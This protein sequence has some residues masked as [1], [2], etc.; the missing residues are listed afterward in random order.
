MVKKGM[1][2]ESQYICS[3]ILNEM[4]SGIPKSTKLSKV[5]SS[6]EFRMV[7]KPVS[8]I[9]QRELDAKEGKEID[10]VPREVKMLE[11]CF[12]E[13][14]DGFSIVP[15]KPKPSVV[16]SMDSGDVGVAGRAKGE[17]R[18]INS[19]QSLAISGSK[20]KPMLSDSGNNLSIPAKEKPKFSISP[21]SNA[22]S[23]S[24]SEKALPALPILSSISD[25]ITIPRKVCSQSS[26]NCK[27]EPITIS[28][29]RPKASPARGSQPSM[30]FEEEDLAARLMICP[31]I[32]I[33][34]CFDLQLKKS[35]KIQSIYKEFLLTSKPAPELLFEERRPQKFL[36]A[37]SFA[38]EDMSIK[39]KP[40]VVKV[41]R[42]TLFSL[43]S[44]PAVDFYYSKK[45]F[46][47][48]SQQTEKTIQEVTQSD[49]KP[50]IEAKDLIA[51]KPAQPGL[52]SKDTSL[53]TAAKLLSVGFGDSGLRKSELDAIKLQVKEREALRLKRKS[54]AWYRGTCVRR[55]VLPPILEVYN[56][57]LR[58]RKISKVMRKIKRTWAPYII[59]SALRRWMDLKAK[60]KEEIFNKFLEYSAVCIQRSF[61]GFRVRKVYLEQ[62]RAR[63]TVRKRLR[64]L[65]RLWKLKKILM[66]RKVQVTL[67]G[68]RD[69]VKLVN[70]IK[71]DSAAKLLYNQVLSQVPVLRARLRSD[72]IVLYKNGKWVGLPV[73]KYDPAASVIEP[74]L[75]ESMQKSFMNRD[76]M[77][78]R[79]LNS[80]YE[81]LAESRTE[82]PEGKRR[83]VSFLK[84]GGGKMSWKSGLEDKAA[85][86]IE[87]SFLASPG[88]EDEEE[89]KYS[90][91]PRDFLKRSSKKVIS[92]KL[93]WKA[94]RRID[95]WLSREPAQVSKE[96]EFDLKPGRAYMNIMHLQE[97]EEIFLEMSQSHRTIQV[98]LD[99]E[100]RSSSR[101]PAL[102]SESRFI[103]NFS[104]DKY[105]ENIEVL[106]NYYNSLCSDEIVNSKLFN[107]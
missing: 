13:E 4:L 9:F 98:Y 1:I 12:K 25:S 48:I 78:I 36:G 21:A 57:R 74:E 5:L 28:T 85:E 18:S 37:L 100:D 61:R 53:Q 102:S 103:L 65:L 92:Q 66:T 52:P 64:R 71:A 55:K 88:D 22:L 83:V 56:E 84:K 39:P 104:D 50:T 62:N 26:E 20:F 97:L 47:E 76:E 89:S 3:S 46:S 95:C 107:S 69:S 29:L 70:D 8:V 81:D 15:E 34:E 32:E 38:E 10:P 27:L 90:G 80:T 40:A 33:I 60:E 54:S 72:L 35:I 58:L 59:L 2:N 91:P 67:K 41:L 105:Q 43:T 82:S 24:T 63:S 19:D 86:K 87:K 49:L 93:N 17:N 45:E 30:H 42:T 11:S 7:V 6:T 101:I 31:S 68:L 16:L 77:P 75:S 96:I 51:L 14:V 94:E 23:I 73:Y 99:H 44:K 106:E 79:P